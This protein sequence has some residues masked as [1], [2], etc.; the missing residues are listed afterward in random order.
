MGNNRLQKSLRTILSQ[1]GGGNIAFN[2]TA[3]GGVGFGR[4]P[5]AMGAGQINRYY[6]TPLDANFHRKF[7]PSYFDDKINIEKRLE[8][9]HSDLENDV[10]GTKLEK[11]ERTD[12]DK[13]DKKLRYERIVTP[14]KKE[15][16]DVPEEVIEVCFEAL[17]NVARMNDDSKHPFED[18]NP[19][20]VKPSRRHTMSNKKIAIITDRMLGTSPFYGYEEDDAERSPFDILKFTTPMDG[21]KRFHGY[22]DGKEVMDWI[23][24]PYDEDFGGLYGETL[25]FDHPQD[26]EQPDKTVDISDHEVAKEI[27]QNQKE[28]KKKLPSGET[29]LE[30]KR[31]EELMRLPNGPGKTMRMDLFLGDT[32]DEFTETM[33]VADKYKG[34]AP[35]SA[36]LGYIGFSNA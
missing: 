9:F 30:Q 26:V 6:E 22:K 7:D 3:P 31:L 29:G 21:S 25:A 28:Q 8:I 19:P 27:N 18:E 20:Q 23:N 16:E 36:G 33:G 13:S 11:G 4:G 17:L 5:G 15:K 10:K 12:L 35:G 14:E 32:R 1:F 24:H 34:S 2:P